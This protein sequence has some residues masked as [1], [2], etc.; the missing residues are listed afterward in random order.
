MQATKAH[1]KEVTLSVPLLQLRTGIKS[2]L[3]HW[4][5][6]ARGAWRRNVTRYL[7]EKKT[8][9]AYNGVKSRSI[10]T[11]QMRFHFV[12]FNRRKRPPIARAARA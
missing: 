5:R 12:S 11:L 6:A 10:Y 2:T 9:Q 8:P 1:K 3:S 4:S 7:E